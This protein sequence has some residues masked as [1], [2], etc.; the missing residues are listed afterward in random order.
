[1]A[2]KAGYNCLEELNVS[3]IDL[4]RSK[5]QLGFSNNREYG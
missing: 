4:G 1:M 3:K 2:E 5:L